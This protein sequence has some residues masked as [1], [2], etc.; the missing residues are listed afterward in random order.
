MS[1]LSLI[2]GKK[3]NKPKISA[4]MDADTIKPFFEAHGVDMETIGFPQIE[5]R[6]SSPTCAYHVSFSNVKATPLLVD[7]KYKV[8]ITGNYSTLA[9]ASYTDS[10]G[11]WHPGTPAYYAFRITD[12]KLDCRS[13]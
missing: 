10:S 8:S 6:H 2:F 9:K 1:L 7:D 4:T 12:N 3:K 13:L 11:G 5:T